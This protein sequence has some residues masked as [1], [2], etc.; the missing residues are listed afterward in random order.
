MEKRVYRVTMVFWRDNYNTDTDYIADF[1]SKELAINYVEKHRKHFTK[2]AIDWKCDEDVAVDMDIEEWI[3]DEESD[4]ESIEEIG[5]VYSTQLWGRKVM[6]RKFRE[7]DARFDVCGV[8]DWGVP[9][10]YIFK[11]KRRQSGAFAYGDESCHI[12]ELYEDVGKCLRD[13]LYDTRYDHIS[14]Y[15]PAWVKTWKNFIKRNWQNVK[16]V[17]LIGYEEQDVDWRK[18]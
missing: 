2:Q 9:Y 18:R 1:T 3:S 5:V 8:S 11:I 13:D 16:S 10:H 15:K 14:T 4:Y 6:E 7:I 17:K 12:L